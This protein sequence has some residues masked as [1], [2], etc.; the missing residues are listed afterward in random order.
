MDVESLRPKRAH[1]YYA[2]IFGCAAIALTSLFIAQSKSFLILIIWLGIIFG[3]IALRYIRS[4]FMVVVFLIPFTSY[5]ARGSVLPHLKPNE[6]ILLAFLFLALTYLLVSNNRFQVNKIDLIMLFYLFSFIPAFLFHLARGS[7]PAFADVKTAFAPMQYYILYR[8]TLML[9][10]RQ[11]HVLRLLKVMFVSAFVVSLLGI[12]QAADIL[13]VREFIKSYYPDDPVTWRTVV[14]GSNF[15]GTGRVTSIFAG[16]WNPLGMFMAMNLIFLLCL[17]IGRRGRSVLG[18]GWYIVGSCLLITLFLSGS[19]S[20]IIVFCLAMLIMVLID[21]RF[22]ILLLF[23][24]SVL[25]LSIIFHEPIEQ[26]LS[27]QFSQDSLV[28]RTLATRLE[29]WREELAPAIYEHPMFGVGFRAQRERAYRIEESQYFSLLLQGGWLRLIGYLVFMACILCHACSRYRSPSA[30][31]LQRRLCLGIML[32]TL[33]FIVAGITAPYFGYS[34]VSEWYWIVLG[35]LV[36]LCK[37]GE[38]SLR[39]R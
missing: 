33:A 20:S 27:F 37:D 13:G 36:M 28:P 29:I 6:A 34:A 21:G 24:G 22:R 5:M 18:I 30:G 19:F 2:V 39:Q 32:S 1:Q 9:I 14:F 35:C 3:A 8:L 38:A 25:V 15:E 7:E 17:L 26:R 23:L 10:S 31:L 11:E 12:F 4:A 16:A